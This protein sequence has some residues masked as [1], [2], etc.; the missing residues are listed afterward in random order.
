[1]GTCSFSFTKR[2]GWRKIWKSFL[3]RKE[4]EKL[5]R[6]S[7]K[8]SCRSSK[9]VGSVILKSGNIAQKCCYIF[10]NP[11]ILIWSICTIYY[12][13]NKVQIFWECHKSVLKTSH[14]LGFNLKMIGEIKISEL[15][16]SFSFE[17]SFSLSQYFCFIE[18][19]LL[20]WCVSTSIQFLKC[21]S[22][23]VC[24]RKKRP[25]QSGT[26]QLISED[27]FFLLFK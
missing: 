2:S 21:W 1:M 14:F 22:I 20:Q 27:L 5:V 18:F 16:L 12:L 23:L 19:P 8:S 17:F 10:S 24:G 11:I 7:S 9:N 3:P 15:H 26:S 25:E 4:S 6:F 13:V